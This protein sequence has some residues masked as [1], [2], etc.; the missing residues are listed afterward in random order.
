MEQTDPTNLVR[1]ILDTL[2]VDLLRGATTTETGDTTT[3]KGVMTTE[4]VIQEIGKYHSTR[5]LFFI[6]IIMSWSDGNIKANR[7]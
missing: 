1:T 6:T 7:I 5:R 4:E 2:T 3:V